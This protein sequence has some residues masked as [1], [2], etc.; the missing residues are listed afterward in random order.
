VSQ[1]TK[2]T[3]ITLFEGFKVGGVS[4]ERAWEEREEKDSR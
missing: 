2:L 3:E 1:E 4:E